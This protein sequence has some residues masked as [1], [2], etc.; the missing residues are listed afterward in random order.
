MKS[1][2]TNPLFPIKI[3]DYPKLFD[4]VLTEKGLIFF[5][6]IKRKYILGKDMSLDEFNKLRLLYVYYALD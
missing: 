3:D 5:H 6:T 1:E 4:Y 2:K